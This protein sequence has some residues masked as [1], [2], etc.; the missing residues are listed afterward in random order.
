MDTFQLID[1]T[2]VL[3]YTM[4]KGNETALYSRKEVVDRFGFPPERIPDYKAFAGDS[5]DNIIGIAGIGDK[6]ATELIKRYGKVEDVYK[7]LKKNRS[8]LLE[9]GFKERIVGLLENG[10]EDALF[11][12]TLATIRRDAPIVYEKPAETWLHSINLEAYRT[13]CEKYE[14]RSL[15]TKLEQLRGEGISMPEEEQEKKET[16][17]INKDDLEELRVMVN[18]LHS[19]MTNVPVEDIESLTGK[20]TAEEMKSEL[21]ERLKK[22]GLYDLFVTLEKPLMGPVKEM[23]TNGIMVDV[24]LLKKMSKELHAEVKKLE[25]MIHGLAGEEFNIASPKQLGDILYEKLQLGTKIKK[26]K[27][28]Q[29]S[30]GVH[31]LD[32]IKDEHEIVPLILEYRELTKLLSTYIDT[33]LTV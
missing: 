9:D 3:V 1:G 8:K 18:L 30:T 12:K 25:K 19:E 11:S 17:E 7:A 26:T 4:R 23:E 10:E 16:R 28:G 20:N 33:L 24:D 2:K 14:F 13:M 5:S 21:T 22:E 27:T 15:R 6:T 32:K 29:K 31:E